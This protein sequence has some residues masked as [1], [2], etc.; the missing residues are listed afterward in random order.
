MMPEINGRQIAKHRDE[1]LR[2]VADLETENTR[3][4]GALSRIKNI[5]YYGAI[6]YS[7]AGVRFDKIERVANSFIYKKAV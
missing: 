3:L 6:L 1:L 5:A 2:R 4:R 7:E